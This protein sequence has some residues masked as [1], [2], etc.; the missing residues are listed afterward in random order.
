[1]S[2]V[3]IFTAPNPL[4]TFNNGWEV[5]G[6]RFEIPSSLLTTAPGAT[7][8]RVTIKTFSTTS[9]G[10]IDDCWIGESGGLTD[11]WAFDGNQVQLKFSGSV[12]KTGI[13][14]AQTIV[15]DAATFAYNQAKTLIVA[16]H[17]SGTHLDLAAETTVS[18]C[19]FDYYVSGT[20]T[21][22]Q[23]DPAMGFPNNNGNVGLALIEMGTGSADPPFG[24]RRHI[25]W[26]RGR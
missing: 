25:A 9:S 19:T 24:L 8:V 13:T 3:T 17:M 20:S 11:R 5:G 21:S 4:S 2:F 1:M 23:T 26:M 6:G 15:T 7:L 10:N 12:N 18:A 22:S 16:M 14:G